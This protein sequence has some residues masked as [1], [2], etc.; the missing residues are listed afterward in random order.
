MIAFILLGV[1]TDL[2]EVRLPALGHVTLSFVPVLG[3]LIAF[4]LW[5]ALLVSAASGV[6]TVLMTR[7]PQKVAFNV[8]N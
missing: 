7:D 3:A 6:A 2:R 8:G 1:V 4:G 5:P